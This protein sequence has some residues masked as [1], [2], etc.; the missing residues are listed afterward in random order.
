MG[1]GG[2]DLKWKN[3]LK[4]VVGNLQT[5]R[6]KDA[7]SDITLYCDGEIFR[8]HKVL[9]AACSTFFERLL[10]RLPPSKSDCVVLLETRAEMLN[11][12]LD[13]IYNGEVFVAADALNQFMDTAEKLE[14]RGLRRARDS[15]VKD[16][17][18]VSEGVNVKSMKRSAA[19]AVD[20]IAPRVEI[21]EFDEEERPLTKRPRQDRSSAD[22][23]PRSG[24]RQLFSLTTLV[25]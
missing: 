12:T 7:F 14:I 10:A 1:E 8:A 3:H 15:A 6:E 5:L 19:P 18:N 25:S 11:L 20:P 4:E 22:V 2:Y 9:L 24:V 23:T 17:P 13:F 16:N 21:D